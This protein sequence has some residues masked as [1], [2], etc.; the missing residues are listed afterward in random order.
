MDKR[1][2]TIAASDG[3]PLAAT[4]YGIAA[5]GVAAAPCRGVVVINSA[6]GVRRGRYAAYAG[7]L[8]LRGYRVV[9]YDYRGIG[10]STG[11]PVDQ[12]RLRQW[13]ELDFGGVLAWLRATCPD[14]PLG[15]VGHS[16]GGQILGLTPHAGNVRAFLGIAAQSGYWRHWH[17]RH[18]PKLLLAWYLV[19]PLTATLL[20]RL[21]GRLFGAQTLPKTIARDWARWC[22]SPHYLC[23]DDGRPLRPWFA[24]VTC[25]TLLLAM[26][27]DAAAAPVAAVR[28]LAECYSSAA[29]EILVVE[30]G[31][32]GG[33][34]LGHFGFFARDAPLSLWRHTADWFDRHLRG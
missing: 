24:Q 16:L 20:G 27:D 19:V 34:S 29:P 11:Q 8:H 18:W 17:P 30:P 23:E 3:F 4:L 7:F 12:A 28:A 32:W 21:P 14:A 13:G 10:G 5:D 2:V 15:C 26:A 6:I 25:P 1:E 31:E 9:T 33:K 22:R